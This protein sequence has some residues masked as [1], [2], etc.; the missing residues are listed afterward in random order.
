MT[1]P[2]LI[3]TSGDLLNGVVV[4]SEQSVSSEDGGEDLGF[5]LLGLLSLD[6]QHLGNLLGAVGV[7]LLV[8]LLVVLLLSA[9]FFSGELVLEESEQVADTGGHSAE[10]KGAYTIV[11]LIFKVR[12]IETS[13]CIK[14]EVGNFTAQYFGSRK[15]R[16]AGSHARNLQIKKQWFSALD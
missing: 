12:V 15:T 6:V 4:E 11:L 10:L 13:I 3:L 16:L 7:V 14:F 2:L 8:G 9:G 5:Y 1:V